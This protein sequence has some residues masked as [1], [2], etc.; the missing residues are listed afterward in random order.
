VCGC[1]SPDNYRRHTFSHSFI[2]VCRHAPARATAPL[3]LL[4]PPGWPPRSQ[5]FSSDDPNLLDHRQPESSSAIRHC[6][7]TTRTEPRHI[8]HTPF[9]TPHSSSLLSLHSSSLLINGTPISPQTNPAS[10][11]TRQPPSERPTPTTH[12]RLLASLTKPLRRYHARLPL[13]RQPY[14]HSHTTPKSTSIRLAHIQHTAAFCLVSAYSCIRPYRPRIPSCQIDRCHTPRS[15]PQH[16][17][18]HPI[19]RLSRGDSVPL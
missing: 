19:R 14:P 13:R 6:S 3:R 1:S 7:Q 15:T 2:I 17:R 12:S 18:S 16:L 10:L 9:I 8:S 11:D 4:R 5:P